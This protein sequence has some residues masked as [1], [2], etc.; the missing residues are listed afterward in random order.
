MDY[1]SK[2]NKNSNIPK[3]FL[4]DFTG[5]KNKWNKLYK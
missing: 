5:E 2:I 4:T 1:I 3:S